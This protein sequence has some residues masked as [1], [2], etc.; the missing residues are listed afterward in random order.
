MKNEDEPW[1]L[2]H[3]LSQLL[4][5]WQKIKSRN[6]FKKLITHLFWKWPLLFEFGEYVDTVYS[7]ISKCSSR[8]IFANQIFA[9]NIWQSS[10]DSQRVILTMAVWPQPETLLDLVHSTLRTAYQD[11]RLGSIIDL[12]L[13][14]N[15][16]TEYTD[17]FYKKSF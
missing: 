14:H 10:S 5:S 16:S 2:Q 1:C 9:Q 12:L 7:W 8:T 6:S 3:Q 17:P 13:L 4:H 15:N 11:L